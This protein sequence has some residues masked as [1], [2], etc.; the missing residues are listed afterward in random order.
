MLLKGGGGGEKRAKKHVIYFKIVDVIRS[1]F[2]VF[3]VQ[4][5]KGTRS[6]QLIQR[7]PYQGSSRRVWK[8]QK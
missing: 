3:V 1:N 7:I 2:T 6:I 8:F 4:K 5:L